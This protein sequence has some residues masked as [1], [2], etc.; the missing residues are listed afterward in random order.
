M[1]MAPGLFTFTVSLE[2]YQYT[3]GE[4]I[5]SVR[6]HDSHSLDIWAS[7]RADAR[8]RFRLSRAWTASGVRG[9]S[10][11]VNRRYSGYLGISAERNGHTDLQRPYLQSQLQVDTQDTSG[12]N[13]LHVVPKYEA[14]K[15]PGKATTTRAVKEACSPSRCYQQ[16]LDIMFRK[17]PS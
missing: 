14:S 16:P 7:L 1:V 15:N 10:L 13:R 6:L 5:Q 2:G 11:G 4:L 8:Y 17:S 12:N 3:W 9:L